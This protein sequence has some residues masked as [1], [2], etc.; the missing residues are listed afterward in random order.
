METVSVQTI[1]NRSEQAKSFHE[2]PV[3][4][5]VGFA[6]AFGRRVVLLGALPASAAILPSAL[7]MS[8]G[9]LGASWA[10]SVQQV[11]LPVNRPRLPS[12]RQELGQDLGAVTWTRRLSSVLGSQ[13]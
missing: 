4:C 12:L 5:Q 9:S 8:D 2:K 10:S 7:F 11:L 6:V 1:Q 3:P 13:P